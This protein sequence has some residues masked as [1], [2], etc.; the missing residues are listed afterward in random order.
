MRTDGAAVGLLHGSSA[1]FVDLCLVFVW[2][3]CV[4]DCVTV[5]VGQLV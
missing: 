4:I 3:D 2:I 1:L 5:V